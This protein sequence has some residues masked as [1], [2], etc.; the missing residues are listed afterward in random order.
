MC[1]CELWTRGNTGTETLK[2]VYHDISRT[3]MYLSLSL[4]FVK[5]R[6]ISS[7]SSSHIGL[8]VGSCFIGCCRNFV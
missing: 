5:R 1:V 8:E 7:K 3:L 4:S 2:I 6:L